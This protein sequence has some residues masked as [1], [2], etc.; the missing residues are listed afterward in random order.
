[1]A[2][3]VIW[4]AAISICLRAG[5]APAQQ[6]T[7]VVQTRTL[8]AADSAHAGAN[9]KAAIEAHIASG[10]H[11]NDHHPTLAYLIATEAKFEPNK[12]LSVG[13]VLYPKGEPTKFAFADQRLS[14]YQGTVLVGITL[15]VAPGVPVGKYELK[16]KLA[17]QA[18]NESACLPPASAP[19]AFTVKVV[20]RSVSPKR[21]NTDVFNRITVN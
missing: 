15:R 11:I 12:Q 7:P 4:L 1:M 20:D 8:L 18:C 9:L 3:R 19:F 2:R 13:N 10:Y 14:V 21:V 17:Y 6:P 16:G 5:L